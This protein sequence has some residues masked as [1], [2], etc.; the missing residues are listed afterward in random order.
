M[1]YITLSLLLLKGLVFLEAV[2][3]SIDDVVSTYALTSGSS[4]RIHE[5]RSI[6]RLPTA[7][8]ILLA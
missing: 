6:A 4:L 3:C 7:S 8:A 1:R 5:R 2:D